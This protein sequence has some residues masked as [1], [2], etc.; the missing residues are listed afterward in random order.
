MKIKNFNESS[1]EFKLTP[2][3]KDFTEWC[4]IKTI[5]N[6]RYFYHARRKSWYDDVKFKNI[7]WEEIYDVY[8]SEKYE[9]NKFNL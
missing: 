5:Q 1:E 7:T 3:I 4:L 2:E 6:E 8:L 9:T